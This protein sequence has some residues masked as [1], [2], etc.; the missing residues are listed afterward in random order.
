MAMVHF[1]F[2]LA[3]IFFPL[4]CAQGHPCCFCFGFAL[5]SFAELCFDLKQPLFKTN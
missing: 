3:L 1:A 4:R 2:A 5:L